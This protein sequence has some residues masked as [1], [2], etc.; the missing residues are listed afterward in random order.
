MTPIGHGPSYSLFVFGLFF[1][2]APLHPGDY[3][4]E[5][6]LE[7]RG[8]IVQEI[9][10]DLEGEAVAAVIWTPPKEPGD[11][12]AGGPDADDRDDVPLHQQDVVVEVE[13]PSLYTLKA[14]QGA[15]EDALH[16]GPDEADGDVATGTL[17]LFDDVD[18]DR[19][20]SFDGEPI[21]GAVLDLFVLWSA[22]GYYLRQGACGAFE[23]ADLDDLTIRVVESPCELLFDP[24]C[25]DRVSSPWGSACGA[26]GD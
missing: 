16:A 11:G 3:P 15:P 5:A 21:V 9:Q 25:G 14:Y 20:L 26:G 17:V 2:C 13:F 18:G 7:V 1:A 12:P 24:T 4:G 22:D 6:L 10:L 8:D 23:D 19:S